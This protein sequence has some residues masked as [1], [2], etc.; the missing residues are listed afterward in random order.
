[1]IKSEINEIKKLFHKDASVISKFST[2]YVDHEKNI[3]LLSTKSYSLIP[4]EDSFKYEDMFKKTLSGTV[5]KQLL[6]IDIGLEEELNGLSHKLLM[7]LRESKLENEELN[8]KFFNKIIENFVYPE[9]YYIVLANVV[10][11]IPFKTKDKMGLDDAS[12]E[13]YNAILCSICPVNLDK[14][15]LSY[16]AETDSIEHRVRD[17][18]VSDPIRGFLFP[19]FNDRRTDIHA[20][21]YFSKKADDISKDLIEAIFATPAP[22]PAGE[23]R[24]IIQEELVKALDDDCSY[25]TISR[26]HE[27]L[28]QMIEENKESDTP[29][30]LSKQDMIK[31]MEQS[32]AAKEAVERYE[33]SKEADIAVLADNIAGSKKVDIKSVGINIKADADYLP[34]ISTKTVEGKKCLVIELND[35]IEINGINIK[36]TTD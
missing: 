35:S 4:E 11:D 33:T 15:C 28:N 26:L 10:Y 23:Q 1:M 27:N 29:L 6:N 24:E 30:V 2:C 13:T 19:A 31:L 16:N 32:G 36:S 25:S 5:G 18:I 7:E 21:L 17:W 3:K 22:I 8:L 20:A 12:E 14:P 9:N 34:Y